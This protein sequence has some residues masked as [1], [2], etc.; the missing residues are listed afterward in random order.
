MVNK[1]FLIGNVGKDP[2]LSATKDGKY[3]CN[4]TLATSEFWT[5]KQ[6]QKQEKTTWH[7]IKVWGKFAEVLGKY[8]KKGRQVAVFGKITTNDWDDKEGNKNRRTIIQANEVQFVG[9][10]SEKSNSSESKPTQFEP[11]H[12]IN[13]RDQ[14]LLD[15]IPF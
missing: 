11:D 2:I 9:G 1:V 7:N 8:L 13:K 3:V 6:G 10:R 12:S 14:E 5:D 4:F 15:E